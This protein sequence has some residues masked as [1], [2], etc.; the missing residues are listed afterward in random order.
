ML[1]TYLKK[2][3]YWKVDVYFDPD[4]QCLFINLLARHEMSTSP[5][6]ESSTKV[7]THF[8]KKR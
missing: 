8:Y 7:T 4:T 6:L 5:D 1:K 2:G 3:V